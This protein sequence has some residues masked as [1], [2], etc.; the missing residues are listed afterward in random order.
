MC[1]N[2]DFN[3]SILNSCEE[4]NDQ[5]A[6]EVKGRIA[7]VNDLHSEDAVYHQACSANFRTGK[8]ILKPSDENHESK[9]QHPN[10]W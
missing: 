10:K 8:G 1:K 5:W 6:L 7:F 3:L 4:R 9:I 2:R